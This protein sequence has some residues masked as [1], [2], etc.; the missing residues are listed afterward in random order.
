M[1]Q[2]GYGQFH[3][4]GNENVAR[5]NIQRCLRQPIQFRRVENRKNA[6]NEQTWHDLSFVWRR[7]EVGAPRSH[8]LYMRLALG[9][10]FHPVQCTTSHAALCNY[11][12]AAKQLEG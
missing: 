11:T 9:R 3:L 7:H 10:R 4:W 5:H 8:H 2:N 12:S 1:L 6:N